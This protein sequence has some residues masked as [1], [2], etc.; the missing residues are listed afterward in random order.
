[1]DRDNQIEVV[2]IR[3][4]ILTRRNQWTNRLLI[5]AMSAVEEGDQLT[6]SQK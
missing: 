5:A 6:F 1:M 4:S 2:A 3:L